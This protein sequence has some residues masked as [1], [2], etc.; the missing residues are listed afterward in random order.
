MIYRAF[1]L[2][3]CSVVCTV[4]CTPLALAGES[5]WDTA[6]SPTPGPAKVIGAISNGCLL[7]GVPLP[8]EGDGFQVIRLSRRRYYGHSSLIDYIQR[9]GGRIARAGLGVV[10]IGDMSQPRGG[11]MPKGHASH[12]NGI[13]VD[14]W[15]RLDLA[16]LPRSQRESLQEI[17]MTEG[18]NPPRVRLGAWTEA[19][20]TL[21]R[22]ATE[23]PRVSRIFLNPALKK[24]LCERA[25]D[26]RA[27]LRLVRPWWGH[28]GHMHVRLRCPADSPECESQ[29]P[30]PP[31]DGCGE[32]LDSWLKPQPPQPDRPPR[33]PAPQ[34]I[35]PMACR[36]IR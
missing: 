25:G 13:D 2:A 32:E 7:G 36:A 5:G 4:L 16:R 14:F 33:P 28:N 31:G 6:T 19:Q 1:V 23:D 17:I 15:L 21:I 3:V 8:S 10:L 11:P 35:M 18:D 29:P 34:K 30:L 24:A 26:D 20:A 9:F 27:W 12:Q 22:L